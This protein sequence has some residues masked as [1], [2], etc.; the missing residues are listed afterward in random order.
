MHKLKKRKQRRILNIVFICILTAMCTGCG[1]AAEPGD[2]SP[3]LNS[4]T[5][6]GECSG[7]ERDQRIIADL[8]F[9][10]AVSFDENLAEQLRIVVGGQR[11]DDGDV[12]IVQNGENG[13]EITVPVVQV[14]DGMMEITNAPDSEVLSGLTDKEGKSCVEKLEIEQLIPSGASVSTV[15]ETAGRAVYQVDSVVTHRSIIWLRMY[16]NGEMIP[17]DDTDTTDVMDDAAA[18][19]E[20]EFLWATPESTAADMA[21][22]INRYYSSDLEASADGNRLT[23]REKTGK[24]SQLK[25]EIYTGDDM[26]GGSAASGAEGG[27]AAKKADTDRNAEEAE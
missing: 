5:L 23:I 12:A 13:I 20:H 11:I 18:V 19:H 16:R 2:H 6:R 8:S 7:G 15:E 3:V 26:A 27:Q 24:Q 14:N 17:P 4:C 10:R 22:T 1:G 25:L 9:D 21:E